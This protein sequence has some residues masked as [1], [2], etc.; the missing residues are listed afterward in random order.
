MFIKD[1]DL[2]VF[3]TILKFA[4]DSKIFHKSVTPAD[5]LDH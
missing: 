3:S 2:N 4:D 1:L 5:R